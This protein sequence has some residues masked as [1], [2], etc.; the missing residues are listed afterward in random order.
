MT[1]TP[2]FDKPSE[3][4]VAR[5][6]SEA[7]KLHE[8]LMAHN[9]PVA[10]DSEWI[11]FEDDVSV[12]NN[13]RAL[14][15]TFCWREA[16]HGLVLAY[17]SN[18]PQTLVSHLRPWFTDPSKRKIGHNTPVD[19][20][21]LA[22]HGIYA[23]GWNIDTLVMDFFV[24][25]RRENN[26]GLKECAKDWLHRERWSFKDTFGV[27]RLKKDGT[28]YASGVKDVPSLRDVAKT[29]FDKLVR[30][31]TH[32]AYD[33]F[34]LY[35]HHAAIL[36][37]R[38]WS[39]GKTY[40]DYF[41]SHETVVT[42]IICWMERK[43]L[44][45]DLEF[46]AEMRDKANA[47]IVELET[48]LNG[49]VG[50]PFN[51]G[52]AQQKGQILYGTSPKPVYKGSGKN[53]RVIYEIPA[54][55]LP[56][57]SDLTPA[58]QPA[59]D[60]TALRELAYYLN[61]PDCDY[62]GD[63]EYALQLIEGFSKYNAINTQLTNF[64]EGLLE[65]QRNGRVHASI[66]QS[67]PTSG[68]FACRRPNLQNLTTGDK[69]AYHIRDAVHA[70]FRKLLLDIDYS[71]LEYKLLAHMTRDP[72][73]LLAFHNNLDLHSLT[74]YKAFPHVRR[75]VDQKFGELDLTKVDD[76]LREAL[77]FIAA[78][79]KNER[80]AGKTLNFEIIYGVGYTKLAQQLRLRP[81]VA[82]RMIDGWFD[83]YVCVKPWQNRIIEQA[84]TLGHVRTLMGRYRHASWRIKAKDHG[85]RGGEERSL[86]NA[87]VQGSARD[88]VVRAMI[89]LWHDVGF[90][91]TGAELLMQIHDELLFEVP[92][93]TIEVARDKA[94]AIMENL[95]DPPLR[96]KLT[97]GAGIGPT[98]EAAK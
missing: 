52:S 55:G 56:V 72:V 93:E 50:C 6:A 47:D 73:M 46:L 18:E 22:N 79:F 11:D 27:E 37:S 65:R 70:P 97:V 34:S 33:T 4:V 67:G 89:R 77:A 81:D 84:R 94:V 54:L 82:K 10:V 19:W 49:L 68:R 59:T 76:K 48:T 45:L 41:M 15:F 26:H 30:Y 88:V 14:C 66:V 12:V 28:P 39:N 42:E 60:A 16:G 35:E 69:D 64:L 29:D 74:T 80:K 95:F 43:G 21:M 7:I 71:Q 44:P 87:V 5:D 75:A 90:R 83:T 96:V 3:L 78:E 58:G 20:H 23:K 62:S 51:P 32:D 92:I 98:W 38:P 13:G 53:K 57:V 31:A 8:R 36:Q 85:V 63:K 2:W 1:D 9:G 91:D 17:L 24:D 61:S 40:L 25:E 86:V